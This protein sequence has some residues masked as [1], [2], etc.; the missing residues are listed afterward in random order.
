M[1]A[2]LYGIALQ[3]KLDIRSKTLLITCYMVPLLFFAIMGGIFTSIMP[4]SKDTLV[5]AMTVMGASMG[6]LIGLPP[7]LVEIYGSGM[8]KVYKRDTC[9]F[10]IAHNHFLCNDSLIA[11]VC[12][13][14]RNCSVCIW[15]KTAESI[16]FL[17]YIVDYF[18]YDIT[19][20]WQ[21]FRF[22]DEKASKSHYDFSIGLFTFYYAVRNYVSHRF[23]TGCVKMDWNDISCCVGLSI[24]A[25]LWFWFSKFVAYGAYFC[26]SSCD[27]PAGIAQNKNR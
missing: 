16:C 24:D 10:W 7:S 17:F 15:G 27:Y 3:W 26:H 5:P 8:K 13:D 21:Y 11:H 14:I 4:E 23:F 9:L 18:Y 1:K 2:L 22:G 6:A 25:G 19:E 20:R 12:Y